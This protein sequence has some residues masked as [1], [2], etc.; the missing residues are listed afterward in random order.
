MAH[1]AEDECGEVVEGDSD[2]E[3]IGKE[4]MLDD[5]LS[6]IQLST[7][8]KSFSSMS[9]KDIARCSLITATSLEHA[10]FCSFVSEDTPFQLSPW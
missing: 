4:A 6:L 3:G 9:L 1:G 7:V 8:S 5:D 10:M 2:W